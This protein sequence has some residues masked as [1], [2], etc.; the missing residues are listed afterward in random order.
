MLSGNSICDAASGRGP[1]PRAAAGKVRVAIASV[2]SAWPASASLR[3]RKLGAAILAQ[4]DNLAVVPEMAGFR[5]QN[6]GRPFDEDA[7]LAGFS[8]SR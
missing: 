7:Q 1:S 6:I 3:R 2:R 4:G 5:Q 8:R